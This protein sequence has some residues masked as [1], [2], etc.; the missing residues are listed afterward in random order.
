MLE[1]IMSIKHTLK[2]RDQKVERLRQVP[3]FAACTR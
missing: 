2:R 1:P 3:L